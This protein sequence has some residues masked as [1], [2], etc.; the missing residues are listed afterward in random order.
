M[1]HLRL[2]KGLSYAGVVKATRKSPDV[3]ME[4]KATADKAVAS[5]YFELLEI[6]EP[7]AVPKPLD[8]ASLEAMKGEELKK[9]AAD[10]GVDVQGLKTKAEYIT[11]IVT[12]D[13]APDSEGE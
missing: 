11:A 2:I 10:L 7:S 12:A 5:G 9:L 6:D 1:Y 8:T 4:D 3:F 13:T